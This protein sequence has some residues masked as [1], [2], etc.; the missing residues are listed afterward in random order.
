MNRF[1]A[2]ELLQLPDGQ[3][4]K[5]YDFDEEYPDFAQRPYDSARVASLEFILQTLHECNYDVNLASSWLK[6]IGVTWHPGRPNMC[7]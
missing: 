6:T 7:T 2:A 1:L 3:E 4:F 5:F